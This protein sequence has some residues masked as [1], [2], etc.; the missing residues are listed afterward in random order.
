MTGH[1][2][3]PPRRTALSWVLART[4]MDGLR[5][6]EREIARP[7]AGQ[8]LVRLRA[9]SL[10]F[11]DLKIL[12]GIYGA[13]SPKLPVIPLSDGAGDVAETGPGVTRFRPGDRVQAIYMAG[14]HE[15]PMTETRA[16][17]Q[18]RS[19]DIDGVACEYA[20]F[21]EE[22]L[23]SI[24]DGF[25]HAAAACLPCA[26]VTAWH[27]I[28]SFGGIGAG[29]TVLVIGSGG[30]ALFG[31]QI[32]KLRGARAIAI[33]G[34]PAKLE[35]LRAL[36][37]WGVVDRLATPDWASEVLALT[38]GRGVDHVL[39]LA[40]EETFAQSLRAC[41]AGGSIGIVGNLSGAF[42]RADAGGKAV[43][44]ASIVVG[45]RRMNAEV[46]TALAEAGQQPVIDRVFAFTRLREALGYLD[47]GDHFGK[48][49]ISFD[50]GTGDVP[51]E[52]HPGAVGGE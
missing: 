16:G 8:V 15:G 1:S 36:G 47:R 51:R 49:V 7:G 20:L 37:A 27:S 46:M 43:R 11:R 17:W 21:D 23:L 39:E 3:Q 48:V 12:K 33:S 52:M 31:L 28:V 30:V 25:S 44:T 4:G 10:N 2:H 50:T 5:L 32:A 9:A 26:A 24:P 14:W 45:S 35:K 22:D 6:V 18:A 29:N 19:G 13:L 42:P 38:E 41:R 34:S 40:G